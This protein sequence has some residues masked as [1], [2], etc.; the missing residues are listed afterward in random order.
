MRTAF[1]SHSDCLKHEMIDGHPERPERL[2]AIQDQLVRAGVFDYLLHYE[3]PLATVEQLARAHDMLYV[4][5]ILAR[6]PEGDELAHLDPDTFMNRHTAK[7]ALRASGAAVLATDLVIGKKVENA[8]CCVRPPGH[9][10]ERRQAMGFCFFNNVA[11][12]AKH[13]LAEHGLERV[14]IVDFDVHHGNGTEDICDDDPRMM[15]C[16]SYQHPLYPFSGRETMPGRLINVPKGRG[17]IS[18]E[19]REAIRERWLPE[20]ETFQP[21]M[22]FIS[23]GFD[24]HY[25]DEMAQWNLIESDYAW[26]TREIMQL[27]DRHAAGRIV[28]CLE[29]GYALSALGRSVTAHIKVLMEG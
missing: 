6:S 22:I 8:F 14:A 23:A 17:L 9:H 4:D 27:A 7:A 3:A 25:E 1:I 16:S 26:V 28:S 18:K 20:L 10:A 12:A 5:E 2:H 19:F 11:V 24:G 15:V 21:Q 29:G 13:A